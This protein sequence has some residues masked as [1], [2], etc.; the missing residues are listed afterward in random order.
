MTD[1]REITL[2]IDGMNC[3][4][5]VGAVREAL[6]SVDSTDVVKADIGTATVRFDESIASRERLI[7][8]VEEAGYTVSA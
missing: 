3:Q 4:H 5:C 7:T 2:S 6:S 1:K 8:A